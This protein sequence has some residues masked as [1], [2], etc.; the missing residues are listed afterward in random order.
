MFQQCAPE[1]KAR[2]FSLVIKYTGYGHSASREE[3]FIVMI[4]RQYCNPHHSINII[5]RTSKVI[6]QAVKTA[7]ASCWSLHST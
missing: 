2:L 7:E 5:S 6:F 1:K 3:Y 4:V